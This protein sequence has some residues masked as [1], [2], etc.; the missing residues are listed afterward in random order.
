MGTV[1]GHAPVHIRGG[2]LRGI[3]EDLSSPSAQVKSA[4]LLAGLEA[5]GTTTVRE[6]VRTRDHTER[7]LRALGAPI[8]FPEGGVS[9][10]SFQQGGFESS[11]PGD[12]SSAAFLA[13]GPR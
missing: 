10:R 4:I 2:A 13:A 8:E 7:A 5:S 3:D 9:L 12:L 11:V 6:P 1:E